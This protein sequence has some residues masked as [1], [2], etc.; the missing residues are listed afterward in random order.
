MNAT[1]ITPQPEFQQLYSAYREAWNRFCFQ[2][3]ILQSLSP[4]AANAATLES[5]K[6]RVREA[7]V[8]YRARRDE[9]AE[10]ML[11]KPRGSFQQTKLPQT[12]RFHIEQLAYRLWQE[13]GQRDGNAESDWY[14]AEELLSK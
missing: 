11:A 4:E 9:L 5:A 10:Y 13:G 1:N 6:H 14:R 3:E 2:V 7:E 12:H 8:R